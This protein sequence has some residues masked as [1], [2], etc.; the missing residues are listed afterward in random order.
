MGVVGHISWA[1]PGEFFFFL[2]G[3]HITFW[4]NPYS[5]I[6][7]IPTISLSEDGAM[8]PKARCF[9]GRGF[10]LRSVESCEWM[11]SRSVLKSKPVRFTFV[12]RTTN[13]HRI[14]LKTSF[15]GGTPGRGSLVQF[16]QWVRESSIWGIEGSFLSGAIK[17]S[18]GGQR[19]TPYAVLWSV[20]RFFLTLVNL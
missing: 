5:G 16:R 18:F 15:I 13:A 4:S 2:S 11:L 14:Q 7:M 20:C 19:N 1:I 6:N 10:F 8:A 3:I 9:A 12:F 17:V